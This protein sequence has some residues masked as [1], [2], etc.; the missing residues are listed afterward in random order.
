MGTVVGTWRLKL[1]ILLFVCVVG[2]Y[3]AYGMFN[4]INLAEY[5]LVNSTYRPNNT[6]TSWNSSEA[7]T[8]ASGFQDVVFGI[9]NFLSFGNIQNDWARLIL[10]TFITII[11]IVIGYI[12]F[13]FV[14]EFV[15]FV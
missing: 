4:N 11:W 2:I 15:P 5:P 3:S 6:G 12:I 1:I 13:T 10:I 9:G 7:P 8:K 14:K